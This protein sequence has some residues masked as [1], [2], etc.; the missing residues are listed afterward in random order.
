VI[1]NQKC[2]KSN[3]EL[4]VDVF[5]ENNI[6]SLNSLNFNVELRLLFKLINFIENWM[7]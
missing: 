2:Q 5:Y 1:L 6:N 3:L 4:K 7:L